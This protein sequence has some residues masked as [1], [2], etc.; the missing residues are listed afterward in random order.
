MKKEQIARLVEHWRR[1]IPASDL[2]RFSHVLVNSKTDA[3]TLALYEDSLGPHTVARPD[4]PISAN[5]ESGATSAHAGM[6][7]TQEGR[8]ENPLQFSPGPDDINMHDPMIDPDLI[9][10]TAS[11]ERELGEPTIPAVPSKNKKKPTKAKKKPAKTKSKTAKRTSTN[12]S[13]V[14]DVEAPE[15]TINV[16]QPRPRPRPLNPHLTLNSSANTE[17]LQPDLRPDQ[18]AYAGAFESAPLQSAPTLL[19]MQEQPALGTPTDTLH[20]SAPTDTLHESAPTDTLPESA[21]TDTL[22]E[23]APTVLPIQD[24]PAPG[25]STDALPESAPTIA[26]SNP[27]A[28]P[29]ESAESGRP[30]RQPVKR[31]LDACLALQFKAAEEKEARELEKV[32]ARRRKGGEGPTKRQRTA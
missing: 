32:Q 24:Q 1:P 11:G 12:T 9:G 10:L 30:R 2:F 27:I 22:R 6:A 25:N 29:V 4:R 13:V 15:P 28:I 5:T 23:S 8:A 3:T 20:E 17:L 7:S 14:P 19:P 31:K 26:E 18:L 16:E 21:P